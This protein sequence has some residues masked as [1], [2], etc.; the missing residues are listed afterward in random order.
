MKTSFFKVCLA[1]LL[2]V[3]SLSSCLE[4]NDDGTRSTYG[5]F[6]PVS[7][8]GYSYYVDASGFKFVPTTSSATSSTPSYE[9]DLAL[10]QFSYN[11]NDLVQG[12]TSVDITLLGQPS[13]LRKVDYLEE[14]G[15]ESS[16]LSIYEVG[17]LGLWGKDYLIFPFVMRVHKSTTTATLDTELNSHH[18]GLYLDEEGSSD[19]KNVL[20]LQLKY[21]INDVT[22]NDEDKLKEYS[23]F[24]SDYHYMTFDIRHAV[25]DYQTLNGGEYPEKIEV[26]YQQSQSGT[27]VGAE[28]GTKTTVSVVYPKDTADEE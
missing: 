20:R 4:S 27:V 10:V 17:R 24:Y 21:S 7:M 23:L 3:F 12:A 28:D 19:G 26:S 14:V 8:M 9:Y 5:F 22:A 11:V 15:E 25:G 16:Y 1:A 2:A 13:Y 18:F 6:K